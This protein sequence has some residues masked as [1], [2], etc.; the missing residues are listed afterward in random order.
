MEADSDSSLEL[1]HAIWFKPERFLEP[2]FNVEAYV[3]D[4]KRYV[5]PGRKPELQGTLWLQGWEQV[6]RAVLYGPAAPAVLGTV[7]RANLP[8]PQYGSHTLEH[9]PSITTQS[10]E[11][12]LH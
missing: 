9:W 8:R 6:F 5:R 3:A 2:N 12:S 11:P 1:S 7:V 4:L 10:L